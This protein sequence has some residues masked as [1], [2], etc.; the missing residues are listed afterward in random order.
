MILEGHAIKINKL[1]DFK[2]LYDI[3]KYNDICKRILNDKLTNTANPYY[4]IYYREQMDYASE[5]WV[6]ESGYIIHKSLK[7][8]YKYINPIINYQDI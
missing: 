8:Y 2:N 1:K 5:W 3:D 4:L 6:K 7:D